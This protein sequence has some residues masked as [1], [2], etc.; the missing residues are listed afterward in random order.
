MTRSPTLPE[1]GATSSIPP[2]DMLTT[3]QGYS[4]RSSSMKRPSRLTL[5]RWCRRRSS[6]NGRIFSFATDMAMAGWAWGIK[7][8]LHPAYGAIVNS[9][10]EPCQI[11]KIPY[12]RS[13]TSLGRWLV[14]AATIDREAVAQFAVRGRWRKARA[15]MMG[16]FGREMAHGVEVDIDDRL[17]AD[18]VNRN[19]RRQHAQHGHAR[20]GAV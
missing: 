8:R 2:G 15:G 20:I 5:T 14:A 1:T 6:A 13:S 18:P 12:L 11:G 16:Q 4:H 17:F 3:W 19:R 9:A 10:L 7:P